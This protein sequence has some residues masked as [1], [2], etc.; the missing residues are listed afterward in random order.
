MQRATLLQQCGQRRALP[1]LVGSW[2][3][4]TSLDAHA[5]ALVQLCYSSAKPVVDG[6]S[7]G[8][9]VL[10]ATSSWSATPSFVNAMS[11]WGTYY[12]LRMSFACS[13]HTNMRFFTIL[14]SRPLCL[15]ALFRKASVRSTLVGSKASAGEFRK[16]S[17]ILSR[18]T[19]RAGLEYCTARNA[20]VKRRR[21]TRTRSGR[22]GDVIWFGNTKGCT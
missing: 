1:P 17:R 4:R 2:F 6:L 7:K 22:G 8:A 3:Q 20:D 19:Y 15:A 11:I 16:A 13:H 21:Y 14:C 18:H 10:A 9:N 5:H 12:G